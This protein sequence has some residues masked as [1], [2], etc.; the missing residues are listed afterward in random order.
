M[1]TL[2]NV[3]GRK[4]VSSADFPGFNVYRQQM[5]FQSGRNL[6]LV[7]QK[8]LSSDQPCH[9]KRRVTDTAKDRDLLTDGH[10]WTL[11]RSFKVQRPLEAH[12]KP[13]NY[14]WLIRKTS[15][16]SSS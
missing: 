11:G 10:R 9:F 8:N 2:I 15:K 7:K 1:Y 16:D 14:N 5:T 4:P 12:L 6:C 13:D 3:D